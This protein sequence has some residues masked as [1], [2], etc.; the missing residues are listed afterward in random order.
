MEAS[1]FKDPRVL[2]LINEQFVW[3]SLYYDEN[4]PLPLEEQTADY[5]TVG[6]KNRAYQMET[7]KTVASPYFAI[8]NADGEVLKQGLGL[9]GAEEFLEWAEQ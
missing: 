5:K 2:K 3:V 1:T 7:F 6:K 9:A 8:I 4:T